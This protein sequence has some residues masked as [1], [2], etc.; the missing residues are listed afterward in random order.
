MRVPLEQQQLKFPFCRESIPSTKLIKDLT[1]NEGDQQIC[2]YFHERIGSVTDDGGD[3]GENAQ[4][5]SHTPIKPAKYSTT[6]TSNNIHSASLDMDITGSPLK[7]DFDPNEVFDNSIDDLLVLSKK[8]SSPIYSGLSSRNA[9]TLLSRLNTSGSLGHIPSDST[10]SMNMILCKT[11]Q[12]NLLYLGNRVGD[13][14]D[15]CKINTLCKTVWEG[16][17]PSKSVTGSNS[18]T[19]EQFVQGHTAVVVG[20]RPVMLS[21]AEYLLTGDEADSLSYMLLQSSWERSDAFLE[22]PP[23]DARTQLKVCLVQGDQQLACDKQKAEIEQVEA[24]ISGLSGGSVVW[25]GRSEDTSLDDEVL[26]VLVAARKLRPT[27]ELQDSSDD[28]HILSMHA[29]QDVDITDMLWSVLSRAQ[30]FA[31]L[32]DALNL[33]FNTIL[34]DELR[35]FIYSANKSG[36]AGILRNLIRSGQLPDLSGSTPLLLLV[37]MG[38]EKL[39]RDCSHFL[40]ASDL[41]SR[42]AVDPYL[43]GSS[44]T[45]SID[46]LKR[47]HIVV[48]L[49]FACQTH[50]NLPS[51]GLKSLVHS[52]LVQIRDIENIERVELLFQIQTCDVKDQLE[53]GKPSLWQVRLESGGLCSVAQLQV[54]RPIEI[55]PVASANTSVD[56]TEP[57]YFIIYHTEVKQI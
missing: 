19:L 33:L 48:Q 5:Q 29:R 37:E 54:E 30:S 35:P 32:S 46:L 57:E 34:H 13:S 9:R 1:G 23:P 40:L 4:S 28:D 27:V 15:E 8:S 36:M 22:S 24:L 53:K 50:L 7:A 47:L 42:E 11:D 49:S 2:L 6:H 16:P 45:H 18:N 3:G 14:E 21:R 44:L 39:K 25:N 55:P 52:A 10:S 17:M 38:I 41:S 20:S 31:E 56:L 12:S 26:E 51:A 43:N